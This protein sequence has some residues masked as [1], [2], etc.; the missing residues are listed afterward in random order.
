[1]TTIHKIALIA[2]SAL[3]TITFIVDA[4]AVSY[5]WWSSVYLPNLVDTGS[6]NVLNAVQT[7]IESFG[8]WYDWIKYWT[9]WQKIFWMTDCSI[10]HQNSSSGML[11]YLG[12]AQNIWTFPNEY[13]HGLLYEYSTWSST[14][15]RR[16]Q[17]T[18]YWKGQILNAWNTPHEDRIV[19][20]NDLTYGGDYPNDFVFC[21]S[22][23]YYNLWAYLYLVSMGEYFYSSSSNKF[24]KSTVSFTNSWTTN[25]FMLTDAFWDTSYSNAKW[26]SRVYWG[27]TIDSDADFFRWSPSAFVPDTYNYMLEFLNAVPWYPSDYVN[28]FDSLPTFL[29]ATGATVTWSE[30]DDQWGPAT[31]SW[32]DYF[33]DCTSFLDVWCYIKW[34]VNKVSDFISWLFPNISWSW[35]ASTCVNTEN[36]W[37]LTS[38][39]AYTGS[40]V[41][42]Q[43]I[44]NLFSLMMPLPPPNNSEVCLIWWSEIWDD[45]IW[46]HSWKITIQYAKYIPENWKINWM[47]MSFIDL[48]M[49]IL[50]AFAWLH[51]LKPNNNQ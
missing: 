51:I 38:S 40:S 27:A 12:K 23:V 30:V 44:V 41:Y 19:W 37:S 3:L 26:W 15:N 11:F 14:T 47:W 48:F 18:I 20:R 35:Q 5:G 49:L 13:N 50:V 21:A 29:G 7:N 43:N 42:I 34:V 46:S 4:Y 24:F 45:I 39:I 36:T 22:P 33:V 1:M 32:T 31:G 9:W 17:L 2:L 16:I 8:A 6:N 28:D 10:I 25:W